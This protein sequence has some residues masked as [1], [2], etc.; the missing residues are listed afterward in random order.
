MPSLLALSKD[1]A[2]AVAAVFG[3]DASSCG[4]AEWARAPGGYCAFPLFAALCP[5]S[6]GRADRAACDADAVDAAPDLLRLLGLD[7]R[8]I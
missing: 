3:G 6:C 4:A 1:D 5:G 2:A 7:L 8:W